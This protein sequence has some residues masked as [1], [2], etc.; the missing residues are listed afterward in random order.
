MPSNVLDKNYSLSELC[1]LLSVS[2][3]TGKNWLKS[4]QLLPSYRKGKEIVFTG[5]YVKNVVSEIKNGARLKSRRNKKYLSGN[6]IYN[7]YI[8]KNSPNMSSAQGV[9]D[10]LE[11]IEIC[12]DIMIS[13]LTDCALKLIISASESK[14]AD[15]ESY[16][17]NKYA[18]NEYIFL[19]NA[20]CE[21]TDIKK[22]VDKYPELFKYD[23]V[24]EDKEDILGFLY[25]SLK[26]ISNRK[27]AGAYYTPDFAVKKLCERLFAVNSVK[28]KTVFDPCC[29]SGN[30]ILQLPDNIE[31]RNVYASDIDSLGV[32][33]T[34][35]NYAL[36]YKI[37]DSQVIFSHIF[38]ANFLSDSRSRKYDFIIGNPPWGYDFSESEKECLKNSFV[39]A[40]SL[41]VE[42]YDLFVEQA[43]KKL[44]SNGVMS[45]VLPEAILKVKKHKPVREFLFKKN[46][47]QYLEYLGEIFDKVQCPS[48]ILQVCHS[49]KQFT[50]K[51]IVIKNAKNEFV[52]NSNRVVDYNC[53]NFNITDEEYALINKIDSIKNVVKLENNSDFALGIVTG[54]N[55][56]YISSKKTAASEMVLAGTDIY[57]YKYKQTPKYINFLPDKFQQTAPEKFYRAKE[58][59]LY[60]FISN[61][62]VF[63]YDD[64]QVLSLNSCNI[65][66]PKIKNMD[67][68]YI[69]AVLN[70]KIITFYFMKKFN[71]V[72]VLRSYI[73]QIPIPAVSNVEQNKVVELINIL[74]KA[75]LP[76]DIKNWYNEIDLKLCEYFGL[77]KKEYAF[78]LDCVSGVN[79][80]LPK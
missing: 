45:F 41:G 80:C 76:D 18:D 37:S 10:F 52:I 1:S 58:K 29:G 75:S 48:I 68:K 63:A 40:S 69:M 24:F 14:S 15:I 60:K 3:A 19:V 13:V 50:T 51:G 25:I 64:N 44:N 77:S 39:C 12:D 38:F 53:I 47:I 9:I 55:K 31:Y 70:S 79:M 78:I 11:N 8:S 6:S 56:K 42:S 57:K 54:D 62:P 46:S 26:N 17:S 67:M 65:L 66:I 20:L 22:V 5:E 33:L 43:I 16:L 71:S 59:L 4:G 21:N 30:F 7:S 74:L 36:K 23:Y 34:R 73:E 2:V 28:N 27:I 72:K 35:I 61:K 49:N 32:K